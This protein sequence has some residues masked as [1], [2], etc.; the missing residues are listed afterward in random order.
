[1]KQ[2]KLKNESA[3]VKEA[4]RIGAA[5]ARR[6]GA[7]EVE[8]SDSAD[9]KIEFVYRLLVHDGLLQPLQPDQLNT[10]NMRHRLAKWV[11]RQLPKDHKLVTGS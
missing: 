2:K 3:L 4:V 8:E 6:R 7:G 1:M 9:L 11:I 5:Y 10:A